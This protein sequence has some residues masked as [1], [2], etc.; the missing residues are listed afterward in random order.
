[1]VSLELEPVD[2][3]PLTAANPGQFVVLR[4]KLAPD[5]PAIMRSY[6]LSGEPSARC[7]RI[8]VKREPHG[9]AGA[10][11]DETVKIGDV[12]DVS[13]PRGNFTLRPG[14]GSCRVPERRGRGDTRHRDAPRI[15]GR[16]VA[17]G[18]LVAI[19]SP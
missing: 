8:S 1:M 16:S 5:T 17:E 4:L 19:R 3:L 9:V 11:V 10:Y 15:G 18:G 12:L 13:A 14:D 7:Y 6:S 2:G